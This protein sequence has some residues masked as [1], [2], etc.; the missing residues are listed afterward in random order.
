M[1]KE[2]KKK[3]CNILDFSRFTQDDNTI[4]LFFLIDNER[5][6]SYTISISHV[7]NILSCKLDRYIFLVGLNIF[8]SII[9]RFRPKTI[10]ISAG[11]LDEYN[12]KFW[13][14]IYNQIFLSNDLS[15]IKNIEIN[16]S[17]KFKPSNKL[18]K[19]KVLLLNN[20][21]VFSCIASKI[22]KINKYYYEWLTINPNKNDRL[23]CEISKRPSNYI[24]TKYNEKGTDKYQKYPMIDLSIG[25]IS[26][27]TLV[28]ASKEYMFCFGCFP[29]T[30]IC[31]L[32]KVYRYSKSINFEQDF[33]TYF[34]LNVDTNMKYCNITQPFYLLQACKIFARLP[35]YYQVIFNNPRLCKESICE[36]HLN[37]YPFLSQTIKKYHDN[38]LENKELIPIFKELT[39]VDMGETFYNDQNFDTLE[40]E[41]NNMMAIYFIS[42]KKHNPLIIVYFMK[43]Y[44]NLLT[45]MKPYSTNYFLNLGE[46]TDMP[47][48]LYPKIISGYRT[49]LKDKD[50]K[51]N[52][53]FS[54]LFIPKNDIIIIF[55]LV[56]LFLTLYYKKVIYIK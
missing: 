22:L 27:M 19:N 16:S 25:E 29:R 15:K 20:C 14:K 18:L 21:S 8:P 43:N 49:I 13:T 56:V 7:I 38:Y 10:K 4:K 40:K 3:Q 47:N 17:R 51:E 11:F 6:V 42:K 30:T 23:L 2:T 37:I 33:N 26:L 46:E 24:H 28:A 44:S 5:E 41:R 48:K 12:K 36:L 55:G 35:K 32:Q 1:K 54:N 53:N 9:S 50:F 31:K 52:L 39:G 34:K 45:K